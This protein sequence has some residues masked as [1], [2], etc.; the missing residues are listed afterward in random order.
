[1]PGF[2]DFLW[3]GKPP[4]SVTSNVNASTNVPDWFQEYQKGI[5]AK[6]TAIAG[7]P[8]QTFPGPRLA[9]FTGDQTQ[10]WNQVRANQGSWQPGLT[11]ANQY[12]TSAGNPM[13]DQN[14]FNSY[15]SPY[16]GGVVNRIAE[17]GGRNLTEN[18]LP[19]VNDTFTGAGQFGSRRHGEFT[20]RAVRDANESILGQQSLALQQAHDA[21]MGNYQTAQG[22]QLAAGEQ[23]GALAQAQ[24]QLGTQDAAALEAIGQTQQAQNQA[25][26]DLAYQ[27]FREQRDY[28]RTQ[29]EW[30]NNILKGQ[31]LPTQSSTTTT[32]PGSNFQPSGL[33][34]L[35]GIY[36]LLKGFKHGGRVR[37]TMSPLVYAGRRM[38]TARGR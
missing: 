7:E 13:L 6:G 8:F 31:T 12:T 5:L 1:M 34:Q 27:D 16:I 29:V 35:A 19:G 4:P 26:L 17:L 18:L 33:S 36:S 32:G 2:L 11:Q 10:A 23:L 3:N 15:M 30:L 21:A 37:P 28:P 38:E 9:D 22:R 25:G 24:S 20:N 14:T